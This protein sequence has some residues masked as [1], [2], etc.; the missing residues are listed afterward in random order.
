MANNTD[1][2]TAKPKGEETLSERVE[3]LWEGTWDQC[4]RQIVD[5]TS[6]TTVLKELDVE[7]WNTVG[8][9]PKDYQSTMCALIGCEM[10][11]M[12]FEHLKPAD[13]VEAERAL[14]ER[15]K[16]EAEEMRI[17]AA[18]GEVWANE[19][20]SD[21]DYDDDEEDDDGLVMGDLP[22]EDDD[23]EEADD[24]SDDD[25]VVIADE[26][27]DDM[28]VDTRSD[29]LD[30]PDLSDEPDSDDDEEDYMDGS[31]EADQEDDDDVH[32]VPPDLDLP[33]EPIAMSEIDDD[34]YEVDSYI[35]SLVA[36]DADL[37][38]DAEMEASAMSQMEP[39]PDMVSEMPAEPEE[40]TEI[41]TETETVIEAG[42]DTKPM[43]E[44][45]ASQDKDSGE[46]GEQAKPKKKKKKKKKKKT[47]QQNQNAPAEQNQQQPADDAET[48]VADKQPEPEL[49]TKPGEPAAVQPPAEAETVEEPPVAV[50]EPE[51]E[52]QE[53]AS[54]PE[55]APEK[56]SSEPEPMPAAD[57]MTSSDTA[58][59][60]ASEPKP[61]TSEPEPAPPAPETPPAEERTAEELLIQKTVDCSNYINDRTDAE[62][63]FLARL[64]G[65]QSQSSPVAI[66]KATGSLVRAVFEFEMQ[67]AIDITR[68]MIHERAEHQGA[69]G[70]WVG[71]MPEQQFMFL[72]R[73]TQA[74]L[75]KSTSGLE[76]KADREISLTDR[77]LLVTQLCN[78]SEEAFSV[79]ACLNE[80]L[81][82]IL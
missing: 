43:P 73:I 38:A 51:P 67:T 68:T 77:Q 27:D 4:V 80:T 17:N 1:S 16:E 52:P 3:R 22:D 40:V 13:P 71:W 56:T 75:N 58:P 81:E 59:E 44:T 72:F 32:L 45:A 69:L 65:H 64:V 33:D 18:M 70:C 30:M 79:T 63:V 23:E 60:P 15:N 24:D 57:N 9:V 41:E 55:P 46:S 29:D 66:R 35:D 10:E 12:D 6:Q 8:H 28:D 82:K 37:D 54:K 48:M 53:T 34:S 19:R 25:D 31:Y 14:A 26:D 42:S 50:M 74:I 2:T 62:L 20:D 61:E 7:R 21:E 49:E 76:I 36:G 11:Q 39:D 78:V 47:G 5:A